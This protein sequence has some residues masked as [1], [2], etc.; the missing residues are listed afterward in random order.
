MGVKTKTVLHLCSIMNRA[1]QE[2]FI[3]NL[4]RN[5]DRSTMQFA[6]LCLA[7]GKGDL[8]DEIESLGGKIYHIKQKHYRIR[9]LERV[10]KIIQLVKFFHNHKEIDV[11]HIHNYHALDVFEHLLASKWCGVKK[12]VVHSHNSEAPRKGLHKFFRKINKLFKFDKFACSHL[13]AEWLF[14]PGSDNG[15]D[16]RIIKNGTITNMYRFSNIDRIKIRA[17]LGISGAFVLGHIGRF[18]RQKNHKYLIEIFRKVHASNK[19]AVLILVGVGEL[20]NEIKILVKKY[21]LLS[22]VLFLGLRT[23]IEVLLSAMDLFLFPSLYEGFSMVLVEAQTNGLPCLISDTQDPSICITDLVHSFPI[24]I[25]HIK[26]W[27][28]ASLSNLESTNCRENYASIVRDKGYDFAVIA[29]EL[30]NYY[31]KEV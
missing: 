9:I 5:I 20:E 16:V 11:Y 28:T 4:Y 27:E 3:M 23:D 8:D 6:F 14:G 22:S 18:S 1:G 7:E 29:K 24:D 2:T 26:E 21:D 12:V 10:N 13:A 19:N 25:E 31:L 30:Q 15:E 17:E